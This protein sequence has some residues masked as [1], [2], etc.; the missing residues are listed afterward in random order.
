MESFFQKL[1]RWAEK[2]FAF[3]EREGGLHWLFYV[4]V[5]A[6]L[7]LLVFLKFIYLPRRVAAQAVRGG[8]ARRGG[9]EHTPPALLTCPRCQSTFLPSGQAH[10]S[11]CPYCS[12]PASPPP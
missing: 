11:F 8:V 12:T 9:D 5:G 10:E 3:L 2:T 6:F 1:Y 4:L 7:L